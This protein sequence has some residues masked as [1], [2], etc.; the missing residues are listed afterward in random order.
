MSDDSGERTSWRSS[1][2]YRLTGGHVV[3][4]KVPDA[5]PWLSLE[6]ALVLFRLTNAVPKEVATFNFLAFELM[7]KKFASTN[8][9][10]CAPTRLYACFS[11]I[12]F[13][14]SDVPLS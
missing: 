4:I 9:S 6:D 14:P 10:G 8:E 7:K 12:F 3:S 1:R 2:P 11:K 5:S 13:I